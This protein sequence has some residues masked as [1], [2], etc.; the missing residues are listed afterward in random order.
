MSEYTI[1][2]HAILYRIIP[3]FTYYYHSIPYDIVLYCTVGS[4]LVSPRVVSQFEVPGL[5]P[6]AAGRCDGSG[7]SCWRSSTTWPPRQAPECYRRSSQVGTKGLARVLKQKCCS[8]CYG[9]YWAAVLTLRSAIA[10]LSLLLPSRTKPWLAVEPSELK[11]LSNA[12][13]SPK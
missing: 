5:L 4:S 10:L 9:M 1:P 12:P 13:N 3:C 8:D 2:Y 6:S 11:H 7:M